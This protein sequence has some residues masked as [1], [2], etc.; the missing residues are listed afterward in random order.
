MK[1]YHI[2]G[3]ETFVVAGGVA[4]AMTTL[5]DDR[6]LFLCFN[7]IDWFPEHLPDAREYVTYE[8]ILCDGIKSISLNDRAYCALLGYESA[9]GNYLPSE[10]L[11]RLIAD[12]YRLF[13]KAE[14]HELS[15]CFLIEPTQYVT[16][17]TRIS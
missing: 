15:E 2:E 16:Q 4:L 12:D 14:D 13:I 17:I 9:S 7:N 8:V 1:T 6:P 10:E 11:V 5:R 3:G